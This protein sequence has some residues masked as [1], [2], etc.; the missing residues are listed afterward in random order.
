MPSFLHPSL[1]WTFGAPTLAVVAIPVLIHLINMMRHRRV[2]WAAMEFLVLSQKKNRTWVLLKQLLLLL[3]RMTAVAAIVLLVAQPA[4]RTPWAGFLGGARLHHIVLLDD[5]FS[6]SDRWED[7]SAFAQAKAAI[8]RMGAEAA[9]QATPQS[10]TLLRFSRVGR[11]GRAADPDLLQESVGADFSD[12]LEPQL[13]KMTVTETAAGPIPALQAVAQLLGQSGSERRV[14][15]LVSDFRARQWEDPAALKTE[16][17]ALDEGDTEIHLIDCVDRTRP[18]LAIVALE[19][20]AGIRAA[21]VP[22]FVE[23][24]VRNFGSAA[25]RN[26]SVILGEDGHARPAVVLA[27]VPAGKIAKERFLVRFPNA[28]SHE[29]T[30]RLESDAVEADNFRYCAINLPAEVSVLLVDGDPAARDAQYLSW[31]AAPGG[32]VQTGIRPQIETP[33]YLSRKPLDGYAAINLANV[34]RLDRSAVAALEKYVAEGGGLAFFVGERCEPKSWNDTFYRDGKGLF[35]APLARPADLVID[36]L[37][38]APDVQ[39]GEHFVFRVFEAKRNT[40]LQAVSVSRYFALPDDWKPAAESGTRV[41]ARLRNGAPLMLDR[42]FGKGRVVAFLTTAA[43]T[44]N[45]WA[46]NPSFVV[47]I[48]DLEAYLSQRPTAEESR[49][50]GAPLEL[51]LDP[52]QYQP[53]LR[54]STPAGSAAAVNVLDAAMNGEGGWTAALTDTDRSGF[55]GVELTRADGTRETRRY[56]LNVDASEGDLTAIDGQQIAAGLPG[57]AYQFEPAAAFQS[58]VDARADHNLSEEILFVLIVLLLIEQL[59]ARSAGYHP[60]GR[61]HL[62]RGGAR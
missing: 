19:P 20:A 49:S 53:R 21:G 15:Y 28:G 38:P 1:F 13:A 22:W 16:L 48:Q 45:N 31:A 55:Y 50:V 3:L 24:A 57:V 37:E 8:G 54:F 52:A 7:T 14:L 18:N 23:I 59:L 33:R 43:P 39:V 44:W 60:T 17:T 46:R 27:E 5:S 2:E 62:L 42:A 41:A 26:V 29:I 11:G 30:A 12:A 4:L 56:A 35:P 10:F 58:S 40:F 9:R 6:M 36:R 47:A 34:D 25:A 61:G 32:P 51:N